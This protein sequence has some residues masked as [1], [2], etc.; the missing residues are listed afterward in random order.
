MLSKKEINILAK[1]KKEQDQIIGESKL[2]RTISGKFSDL[3][4]LTDTYMVTKRKEIPK[5]E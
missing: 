2:R 3:F 1:I 5:K 4:P